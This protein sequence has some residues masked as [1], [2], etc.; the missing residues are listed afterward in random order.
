[1]KHFSWIITLPLLVAVVVFSVNN[2]DDMALDL[3]PF[4]LV[5][6]WPTY[7][8]VLLSF[9]SGFLVGGIIMWMSAGSA[10]REARRQRAEARRLA[11]ELDSLRKATEAARPRSQASPTG[12]AVAADPATPRLTASVGN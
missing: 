9:V 11:G 5:V 8:V 3:W 6:M 4:G 7:L 12:T 10:R 1:V 2:I